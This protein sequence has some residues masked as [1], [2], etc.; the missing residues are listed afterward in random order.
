M[1]LFITVPLARLHARA[2]GDDGPALPRVLGRGD[3]L[4][5]GIGAVIGAGIFVLTGQVADAHTG[6]AIVAGWPWDWQAWRAHSPVSAM[7]S[8]PLPFP[9][10]WAPWLPLLSVIVSLWLTTSLPRETWERL[11][12]WMVV[13]WSCTRSMAFVAAS[14]AASRRLAPDKP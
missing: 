3:L 6:P 1:S 4:S 2:D 9:V 14:C 8:S 13:G 5:L 7:P 12:I 11:V 10:P